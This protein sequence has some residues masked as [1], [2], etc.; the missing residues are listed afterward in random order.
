MSDV[1]WRKLWPEEAVR[2]DDEWRLDQ[3]IKSDNLY[4][5]LWTTTNFT[6]VTRP[7]KHPTFEF[8]R[9]V[10]VEDI[11]EDNG[12]KYRLLRD[13]DL[14]VAD[15]QYQIDSTH[16]GNSNSTSEHIGRTFKPLQCLQLRVALVAELLVPHTDEPQTTDSADKE[17]GLRVN[18]QR[19]REGWSGPITTEPTTTC[20][21]QYG[22]EFE[23]W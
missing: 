9:K 14:I 2:A 15:Y 5:Y 3:K 11:I 21:E 12:V 19:R 7:S 8:R 22:E 10:H 6:N 23:V 13:G 20:S 1:V 17:A 4:A 18:E 16:W